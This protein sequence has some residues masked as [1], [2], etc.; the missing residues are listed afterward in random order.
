M[1]HPFTAPNDEDFAYLETDPGRVRSRAYDL[2]LNGNEVGG[3]SIRIHNPQMQ[4]R[5]FSAL[6]ISEET[7]KER[8]GFLLEALSFG[9]P[10]HGG[11]ALGFDRLIMLL[12]DAKSIREVMAFPKNQRAQCPMSGAPSTVDDKQ[13]EQLFILS[14]VPS[15]K[16]E[17]GQ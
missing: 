10:P 4:S 16:D 3:G 2:I 8:F 13:L 6:N 12:C 7:A 14:T 9:T 5:V 15:E 17:Q 1:H 11:L